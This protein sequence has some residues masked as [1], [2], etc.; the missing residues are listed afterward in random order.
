MEK[1]T[2]DNEKLKGITDSAV[3]FIKERINSYSSPSQL[4]TGSKF[5]Q[6]KETIEKF[7]KKYSLTKWEARKLTSEVFERLAVNLEENEVGKIIFMLFTDVLSEQKPTPAPLLFFYEGAPLVKKHSVI[8]EFN[9]LPEL[10]NR[11]EELDSYKKHQVVLELFPEDETVVEGVSLKL[12]Q[13]NFLILNLLDK[14]LHEEVVPLSSVLKQKEG[15]IYPDKSLITFVVVSVFASLYES[16]TGEKQQ[17]KGSFY[18]A[19]L[20]K[21]FVKIKSYIKKVIS[22]PEE[23]EYLIYASK[24]EEAQIENRVITVRNYETQINVF[25]ESIRRSDIPQQEKI[26]SVFWL[27][28]LKN[29]NPVLL[30]RYYPADD[31]VY[32]LFDLMK[33][34]QD[35]G[36]LT[37]MFAGEM[38]VFLKKLF[39]YPY[40]SKGM[41]NQKT[42]DKPISLLYSEDA[43]FNAEYFYFTQQYDRFLDMEQLVK[44]K[45]DQLKLK[46]LLAR[47]FLKNIEKEEVTGWL[48]LI[49][50]DEAQ[51][52]NHLLNGSLGS[53]PEKNGYKPVAQVYTGEKTPEEV[54]QSIGEEGY[55]TLIMRLLGYYPFDSRLLKTADLRYET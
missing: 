7:L 54:K 43:E 20:S 17:F 40:L 35:S 36:F 21:L 50:L 46:T 45:T 31:V 26:E 28:G 11:I 27:L 3:S 32:Y 29:V 38:K 5:I 24:L 33:Q 25:E 15:R 55:Y 8:V 12:A 19:D 22:E 53:L 41:L 47:Y 9:L 18:T 37:D 16:I 39:K 52:I 49:Q 48:S 6:E 44:E 10:M 2:V 30:L 14:V 23:L 42:L 13:L 34:A 4:L 1:F 51:F